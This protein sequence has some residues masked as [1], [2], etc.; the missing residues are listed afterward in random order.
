M[1]YFKDKK[2]EVYGYSAD[3]P[4]AAPYL[5]AALSNPD[6]VEITGAWPLPETV[7]VVRQKLSND[8]DIELATLPRQW[9]YDSV[10]SASSYTTST[11]P[12][13]AAEGVAL[14]LWRDE[15]WTWATLALGALTTQS[16]TKEFAALF[17]RGMPEFPVRPVIV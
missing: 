4:S 7:D 14:V 11:N 5:G 9:G 6:F 17:L 15:V 8:I 10:L 3:V 1:R 13:F 2:G 12:Q 16:Y